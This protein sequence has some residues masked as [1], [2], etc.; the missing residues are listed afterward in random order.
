MNNYQTQSL[1][2]CYALVYRT[3]MEANLQASSRE[4]S[5]VLIGWI[6]IPIVQLLIVILWINIPIVQ[7]LSDTLTSHKQQVKYSLTS[8]EFV[9]HQIQ[10]L[11]FSWL[12][13]HHWKLHT[14]SMVLVN[15][16][17]VSDESLSQ[18]SL[19]HVLIEE[20]MTDIEQD[21]NL[22]RNTK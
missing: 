9:K 8:W 15:S 7:L 10:C 22:W 16:V 11:L 21:W 18:M 12:H 2:C 6:N 3:N 17:T 13:C 1:L 14:A 19:I 5:D 4:D 20:A